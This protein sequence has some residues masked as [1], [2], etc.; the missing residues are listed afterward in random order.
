MTNI[1]LPQKPW[2]LKRNETLETLDVN[3][4]SGLDDAAV[5]KRLEQFGRNQLRQTERRSAWQIFIEQ[6]KS[7]IVLLLVAAAAISFAFGEI[8]D[9]IAIIAVVLINALI[10]FFTEMRAVR[11]MEALQKI[12]HVEAKVLRENSVHEVNA[13]KLV[14][15]DIVILESGDVVTA[16]LRLLEAAKLQINESA[17]TGESVPVGK[18]IDTVVENAPLAERKNMAYKGTAVTRGSGSGVVV[19]TGMK[20][21]LGKISSLVEEAEAEETPLEERLDRL[22][23]M[24]IIVTLI[25]A[26]LVAVAGILQGRDTLQMIETAIALAVA[27]IPEGLPIVATIALARGMRRMAQRNALVNR[28]AAVE[29]LGGTNIICTD[30]TG[31]LTENQM[32]LTQLT[33]ASGNVHLSDE[34][35]FLRDDDKEISLPGHE[36]F[37]RALEAGVLCNNAALS[38]A[39]SAEDAIGDPVEAALLAAGA[40]VGIYRED[41]LHELPEM[42]EVAFDPD[43]KMMATFHRQDG[44]Y[45]VAAKGAPEAILN[46]CSQLLTE[47]GTAQLNSEAREEWL[48]RN[49][50]MAQSGLRMLAVAE[51]YVNDVDTDPYQSLTL[52]GLVGLLDPPRQDVQDAIQACRQAGIQVVMITGDQAATARKVALAVGLVEEEAADTL[53]GDDLQNLIDSEEH[54]RIKESRILAR[55]SPKQKLD[56]IDIYQREG[57]VVAM[58]GDGVNDAPALKKADIGVAMGKRGTQVAQ[59][60]ADMVLQDDAFSTIVTAVKQGRAIFNNIRKFVLYL[61]SCNLSEIFTVG[62]ASLLSWPL[63]ILPLQILFLNLVTDVFPALALGTVQASQDVMKKPPRDPEEEI[64][65][66]HHWYAIGGYGLLITLA[67]LGALGLALYWLNMPQQQAVTISFLTLA[68]AQLWHVFDM[69]DL[70]TNLFRN[71]ITTNPYIWGALVLCTLLLLIA[72]YLPGLSDVLKTTNPGVNGWLLVLGLSLLPTLTG[73]ILKEF[74]IG[75]I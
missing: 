61:L 31:T 33:L 4:E 3:S 55:V 10:G 23:R 36:V 16:D 65:M 44:G 30:K 24:L 40:K 27:A 63:P 59:E 51:K 71:E 13:E 56:L 68:F 66:R 2:S 9:G 52:L 8:I 18:Q 14:P 73:Q 49:Q 41:L 53:E 1:S 60:A 64:M 20:T 22:G 32:T 15:G 58:T 25:I 12:G 75:E 34:D 67:V 6:F 29:T 43:V 7:L 38:S 37:R 47:D 42:R 39:K 48:A 62:L 17:L 26:A 74:G 19:A 28:L 54:A 46:H 50:K 45:R 57:F 69:R 70:G 5:S 35:S 72:V 21:E 11:S